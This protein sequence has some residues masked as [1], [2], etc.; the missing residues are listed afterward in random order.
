MA[1]VVGLRQRF[2]RPPGRFPIIKWKLMPK[3]KYQG[4]VDLETE[5]R[6]IDMRE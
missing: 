3:T 2:S 5:S 4:F 1:P 6:E